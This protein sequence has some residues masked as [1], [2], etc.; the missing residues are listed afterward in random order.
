[1]RKRPTKQEKN[2]MLRAAIHDEREK[3]LQKFKKMIINRLEAAYYIAYPI[4]AKMEYITEPDGTEWVYVFDSKAEILTH[5]NVTGDDAM[6]LII[7]VTHSI[8][9]D[10]ARGGGKR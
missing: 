5:I 7:D 4:I 9:S 3:M 1:L 10:I 6:S 2:K 8:H